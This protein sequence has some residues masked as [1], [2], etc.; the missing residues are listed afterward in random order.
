MKIIPQ[1]SVGVED[2][3]RS[4]VALQ[5]E[6]LS[7][8]AIDEMYWDCVWEPPVKGARSII[9][10]V[11]IVPRSVLD[12]WIGMF[13]SARL[14]L[15]GASLSSLSWAHGVTVF[16]GKERPTMVVAAEKDYVE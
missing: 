7:P 15:T 1:T 5:V 8:W 11:G 9:V 3:L 6:T 4:A 12:P 16:W 14:A 10:H 2:N 13:R